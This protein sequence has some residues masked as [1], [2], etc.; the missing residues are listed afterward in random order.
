M[1]LTPRGQEQYRAM[2]VQERL[3]LL[4]S[5]QQTRPDLLT[6]EDLALMQLLAGRQQRALDFQNQQN[7]RASRMAPPTGLLSRLHNET[8]DQ[9]TLSEVEDV[10]RQFGQQ[11]PQ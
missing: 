2:P 1:T 8:Y 9:R 11:F 5:A 7:P 3:G 6:K 4:Q 10:Y